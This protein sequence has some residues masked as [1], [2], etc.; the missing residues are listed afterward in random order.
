MKFYER[1]GFEEYQ[2]Q[3]NADFNIQ[4]RF[5]ASCKIEG[6][7]PDG[8]MEEI[9]PMYLNNKLLMSKFCLQKTDL[10]KKLHNNY[11][12]IATNI[13]KYD[14]D[15]NKVLK[16]GVLPVKRLKSVAEKF[17]RMLIH[18]YYKL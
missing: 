15:Q 6:I 13:Y 4:E 17:I 11:C 14:F 9:H 7:D 16:D 1:L 3:S 2:I 10:V 12:P 5:K 8:G 18:N